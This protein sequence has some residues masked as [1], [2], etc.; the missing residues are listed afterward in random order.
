MI[1]VF[2]ANGFEEVEALTPVDLLRRSG[3]E[4]QLVGVGGKVITGSHGIAVQ[5]DITDAEIVLGRE[6]EMMILPGGMPGTLNLEKSEAVQTAIDFCHDREIYI[7]AI[8]AAPSILGHKGLL[9][10]REA[11]AYP[12]FEEQLAG[13]VISEHSVVQDGHIITAQGAGAAVA[14]GLKLAEI[15]NGKE[16]AKALADGICYPVH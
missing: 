11:I 16:K 3:K 9:N 15:F 13:A 8:C 7:A 5:T 6:L 1:Y 14:F 12:G 10:G 4:V 2:L